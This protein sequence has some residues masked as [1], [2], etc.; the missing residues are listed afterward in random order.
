VEPAAGAPAE[1]LPTVVAEGEPAAGAGVWAM[2]LSAATLAAVVAWGIADATTVDETGQGSRGGGVAISPMVY[3][4]RNGMM[5]Y[6]LLGAALGLVLGLV[7]GL[8]RRS[9]G[10]AV[11]GTLVGLAAGTAAGAL[12][13][14]A[15]IPVYDNTIQLN[16]MVYPVLVHAG[17]WGSIGAAAGLA[18]GLGRRERNAALQG[19]VGGL[20]GGI[21]ATF[22]FD[23]LGI[24]AFP[25]SQTERPVSGTT[26]TRLL[27]RVLVGLSVAAGALLSARPLRTAPAASP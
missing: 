4:L 6:G 16:T 11:L 3:I 8:S 18:F 17:I 13:T 25:L 2:A 21:A 5:A 22:L 1:P 23:T 14:R 27:A 15:L 20:L 7:G 12:S 10:G 26:A 19:L 24:L 9:M